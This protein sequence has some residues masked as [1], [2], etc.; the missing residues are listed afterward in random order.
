MPKLM[1]CAEVNE[2]FE[3]CAEVH[4]CRSSVTRQNF[5]LSQKETLLDRSFSFFKIFQLLSPEV[6]TI[7]IARPSTIKDY[8]L[9]GSLWIILVVNELSA[10]VDVPE[11]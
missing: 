1:T 4:P 5:K 7:F 6:F 2:I 9:F 10:M 8:P 11:R 3:I